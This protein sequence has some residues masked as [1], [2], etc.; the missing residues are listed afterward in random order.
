MRST[1]SLASKRLLGLILFFITS[2]FVLFYSPAEAVLPVKGQCS[3]CHTMHNSQN[4]STMVYAGTGA[5]WNGSDQL[6]GGTDNSPQPS[7]LNTSCVGCHSSDS[8]ST[9][10]TIGVTRIPIV[11]NTGGYPANPLAGGNFYN[12]SRGGSENDKYGH[13]V[14]GI[15]GEDANISPSGPGA[16]GTL[17]P[18]G[19]N[20]TCMQQ[21]HGT[22]AAGGATFFGG[23]GCEG[24]H[25]RNYGV[26]HHQSPSWYRFL[27]GH[28]FNT[29]RRVDGVPDPTGNYEQNPGAGHN[30]YKGVDDATTYTYGDGSLNATQ[31]ITDFCSGC[32]ANF[33]EEMDGASSTWLRHPSDMLLPETGEFAGYDPTASYNNLAPVAYLNPAAPVRSE[34]VVMC[35]SCHRAH[36]SNYQDSLRWDYLT[37]SPGSA[38]P[39]CGCF[40]CHSDKD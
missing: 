9:I 8:G 3:L 35:L 15:S 40:V 36:A 24:C 30:E 26:R 20:P 22:L 16:P 5:S 34:A 28:S 27:R 14:H 25:L 13:N 31:S 2:T 1:L 37:C 32:H 18:P 7:L 4:G 11:Y 6:A 21:C 23:N 10:V 39:N 12:V 38:N 33:H 29:L 17:P 19:V